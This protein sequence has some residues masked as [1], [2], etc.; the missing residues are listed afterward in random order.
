M[1]P[2]GLSPEPSSKADAFL[3]DQSVVG[4]ESYHLSMNTCRQG[5]YPVLRSPHHGPARMD[6]GIIVSEDHAHRFD[7][8]ALRCSLLWVVTV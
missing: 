1:K 6:G 3:S 7:R 2:V 8:S 4:M 5:S